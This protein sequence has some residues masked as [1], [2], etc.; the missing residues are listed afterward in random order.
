MTKSETGRSNNQS[1]CKMELDAFTGTGWLSW[2]L[3]LSSPPILILSEHAVESCCLLSGLMRH[4]YIEMRKE[5]IWM[6]LI[7]SC[8]HQKP[9]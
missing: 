9:E 1:S 4:C 5:E 6:S 7:L 3:L 8:F 2:I